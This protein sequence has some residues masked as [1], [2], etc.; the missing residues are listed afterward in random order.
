MTNTLYTVARSDGEQREYNLTLTQAA[1]M[2]LHHDGGDF[3]IRP[4]ADG[5]G[6]DLWSR[7]QVA[8]IQWARTSFF[9][10]EDDREAA[11]ADI[12]QRVVDCSSRIYWVGLVAQDQERYLADLRRMR[13][14]CDAD[15]ADAIAGIDAEIAQIAA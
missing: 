10:L 3:A 4:R 11:E 1:R 9:S 8:N 12:F 13:A 14:Y 15:D 5:E 6:Y 7:Q 2:I